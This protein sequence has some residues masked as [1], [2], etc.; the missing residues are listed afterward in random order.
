MSRHRPPAPLYS[1]LATLLLTLLTAAA[2]RPSHAQRAQSAQTN[3]RAEPAQADDAATPLRLSLEEAIEHGLQHNLGVLLAQT[4]KDLAEGSRWQALSALLPTVA[5]HVSRDRE[6]FNLA[7]FGLPVPEGESPLVGPF[8][9]ID[10]RLTL[11]QSLYDRSAHQRH[12]SAKAGVEAADAEA[13]DARNLVVLVVT[14]LYLGVIAD[15]S[16]VTAAKAQVETASA[17][18]DLAQDQLD[19]GTAAKID[20]LRAKVELDTRRQDEIDARNDL[21]KDKLGLARAVG[22]PLGRPLVLSDTIPFTSDGDGASVPSLET[23]LSQARVHR[24]D[25]A[26]AEARLSAAQAL[27]AAAHGER[28]PSLAFHADWGT[29]GPTVS[30]A[31][32]TYDVGAV[33]SVPLFSGGRVHGDVLTAQAQVRRAEDRLND[34]RTQVEL[35]VRSALLDLDAARHRVATATSARDL[36]DEQLAQARDRFRAGVSDSLEVVQ[37]QQA[38]A[39]AHDRYITSLYTDNLAKVGLARALGVAEERTLDLLEGN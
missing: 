28:L 9:L 26:A 33:V 4:G 11:E 27:L 35:D 15:Q 6:T 12:L 2:P 21:Q 39:D 25:L 36:A 19:A 38:V 14:R 16:R 1:I 23:A 10:A 37:A 18:A 22:V 5:G 17:L 29:I 34:L 24:A 30:S 13:R 20:V 8:D 7:A 32:D 3:Q 31:L